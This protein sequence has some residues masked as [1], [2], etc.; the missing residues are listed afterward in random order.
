MGTDMKQTKFEQD[1]EAYFPEIYRI[2][3]IGEWD[4]HIWAVWDA[5]LEMIDSNSYGEIKIRYNKGRVERIYKTEDKLHDR[6]FAPNL[7]V[8]GKLD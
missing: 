6:K 2:H 7:N 8:T 3:T 1:L 4:K 5:M